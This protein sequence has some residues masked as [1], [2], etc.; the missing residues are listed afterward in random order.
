M[1]RRRGVPR[2]ARRASVERNPRQR[3]EPTGRVTAGRRLCGVG[4]AN[5]RVSAVQ[6]IG[7][8]RRVERQ[9]ALPVRDTER[10]QS[11]ADKCLAFGVGK[12]LPEKYTAPVFAT[13][14]ME[15]DLRVRRTS[16]PT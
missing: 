15:R 3:I 11:S 14:G 12:H 5:A 7:S 6:C 16:P 9:T 2:C 13:R 1:R 8:D 4:C 10:S